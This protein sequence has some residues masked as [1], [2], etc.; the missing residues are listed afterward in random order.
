VSWTTRKGETDAAKPLC[1]SAYIILCVFRVVSSASISLTSVAKVCPQN[2]Q[3]NIIIVGIVVGYEFSSVA[4]RVRLC[5]D[6]PHE[7]EGTDW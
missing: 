7:G 2:F 4:N 3:G 5:P 6:H 1:R